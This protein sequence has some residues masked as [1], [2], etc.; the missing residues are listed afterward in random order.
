MKLTV[1]VISILCLLLSS[2][3]LIPTQAEDEKS[4]SFKVND[5]LYEKANKSETSIKISL[6]DQKAWLLNSEGSVLLMTDV[7][8]GVDGKLTPTGTF[9]VLEKLE[10]KRSNRYGKYVDKKTG[11]VVVAKSWEHK[12]PKPAGT[13]YEGIAMPYWMRLTWYGIGMHVGK[14]DK[15]VRSSFGCIRVLAD[16]QPYL[17]RKTRVG[18]KVE[19]VSKSLVVEMHHAEK[20]EN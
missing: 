2:C 8:T 9:S 12:G 7:S 20:N 15:R 14:F 11:E 1:I 5:A 13:M 18:T 4:P 19:I 10:K 6:W 17:Y 16:A 3:S